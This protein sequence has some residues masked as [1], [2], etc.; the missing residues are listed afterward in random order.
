[1]RSI[2]VVLVTIPRYFDRASATHRHLAEDQGFQD[3]H[4]VIGCEAQDPSS[5]ASVH[6]AI[7]TSHYEAAKYAL[8]LPST[9][10][11]VIME[12]DCRF[13]ALNGGDA[14]TKT[15]QAAVNFLDIHDPEW[16]ILLVGH[17]PLGPVRP[18]MEYPALCRTSF[19]FSAVC[20]VWNPETLPLLLGNIP[21]RHWRRPFM[22]EG[23]LKLQEAHKYAFLESQTT[24]GDVPKEIRHIPGLRSMDLTACV[25]SL[26]SLGILC[27]ILLRGIFRVLHVLAA[28]FVGSGKNVSLS[29]SLSSLSYNTG[30]LMVVRHFP[31]SEAFVER[32]SIPTHAGIVYRDPKTNMVYVYHMCDLNYDGF[33]IFFRPQP[34]RLLLEPLQK[35]LQWTIQ[36]QKTRVAFHRLEYKNTALREAVQKKFD[37]LVVSGSSGP[38]AAVTYIA[39]AGPNMFSQFTLSKP[40][41]WPFLGTMDYYSVE[42]KADSG[43]HYSNCFNAVMDVYEA[44]GVVRR[45]QQCRKTII[46]IEAFVVPNIRFP[47]RNGFSFRMAS[48]DA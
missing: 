48:S 20:Y 18:L 17:C 5:N 19:P 21:Q 35:Y 41:L 38:N 10:T 37:E 9:T 22:V 32:A 36:K 42:G 23:W 7:N 47:L 25:W 26:S 3:I 30:D 4:W 12:D 27:G 14:T 33:S 31:G 2:T 28:L 43:T 24:M 46:N 8:N 39:Q 11:P 6:D 29:P 13:V 40:E 16:Q 44:L 15:I 1:M 45:P 34:N